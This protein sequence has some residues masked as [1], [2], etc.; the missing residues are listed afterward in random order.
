MPTLDDFFPA[1]SAGLADV[2]EA[3]RRADL[4]AAPGFNV[5][6]YIK[7]D[8]NRLSD[9][10]ADLLD[11]AGAHGQGAMFLADFLR[12]AALDVGQPLDRARVRREVSTTMLAQ[13]RRI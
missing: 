10:L 13:V 9:V 11:P 8:E 6:P 1:V 4:Q 2:R 7:R 3:K 12:V 5:F